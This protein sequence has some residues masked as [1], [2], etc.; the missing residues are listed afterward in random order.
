[1]VWIEQKKDFWLGFLSSNQIVDHNTRA[2]AVIWREEEKDFRY[3][4]E[5]FDRSK[6]FTDNYQYP[7]FFL[8]EMQVEY[9]VRYGERAN[10]EV[11]PTNDFRPKYFPENYYIQD[12]LRERDE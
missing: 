8:A 2:H 3:V 12:S 9:F 5:S 4:S 7:A 10:K 1:M 11:S 6:I